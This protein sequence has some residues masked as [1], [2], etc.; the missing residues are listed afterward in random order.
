[1]LTERRFWESRE[2]ATNGP[3][4]CYS[5]GYLSY[6]T[7]EITLRSFVSA[8]NN[9]SASCDG[10]DTPPTSQRPLRVASCFPSCHGYFLK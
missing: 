8:L 7:L 9:S 2:D 10:A 4:G 5:L 6:S 3:S 1:M